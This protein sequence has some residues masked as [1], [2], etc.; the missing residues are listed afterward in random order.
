MVAGGGGVTDR[1]GI[2]NALA[3]KLNNIQANS[4]QREESKIIQKYYNT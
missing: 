3:T 1:M 4:A 2:N